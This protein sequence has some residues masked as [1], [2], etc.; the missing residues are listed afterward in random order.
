M[1][2]KSFFKNQTGL[3]VDSK[4]AV[5]GDLSSSLADVESSFHVQERAKEQSYL[6]PDIDYSNLSRHVRY[7]LASDYYSNSFKRI[8][9]QYPYDGSA[10]EKLEFYNNLTPFEKYV[11]DDLYPKYNGHVTLGLGPY[12]GVSAPDTF[13]T[14]TNPQYIRFYGGPHEGN[15]VDSDLKQENNLHVNLADGLTVEFWFKKDGWADEDD[16]ETYKEALV[17]IRNES[18]TQR[19]YLYVDHANQTQIFS[20]MQYWDEGA[21]QSMVS[22]EFETG[23]TNIADNVWRH[24]AFTFK[25]E[26]NSDVRS[27]CYINGH[28]AFALSSTPDGSNYTITGSVVGTIN[29]IGGAAPD[30]AVATTGI[31]NP[32]YGKAMSASYDEFRIWK[33]SRTG[34]QIGLNWFRNVHGGT[35]SDSTKYFYD[36]SERY[37]E[38]DLAVYFK[39]NE[40]ISSVSG[41][42]TFDAGNEVTSSAAIGDNLILDYSG[43][44][45]NGVFIGYD[46]SLSMRSEDSAIVLAIPNMSEEKDPLLFDQNPDYNNALVPLLNSGSHHDVTNGAALYNNIP[47]WMR[48]QDGTNGEQIKNLFQIVGSYF[49]TVHAQIEHVKNFKEAQ[50]VSSSNKTTDY[51][52]RLLQSSG[53][54]VPEMFVD[55]EII[56]SI[57][58]QDK[59]RVFETK[60]YN[61]KNKVYKNIYANLVTILKSKGTEKSFR[62]LFRCYGTDDELFKINLYADGVEYQIDDKTYDSVVRKRLVDF[63]GFESSDDRGGVLYQYTTSSQG[64]YGFYPTSSIVDIP[65][66][67]EAQILFPKKP[68]IPSLASLPLLTTSSLFGVHSSSYSHTDPSVPPSGDCDFQVQTRRNS[69]GFAQFVLTS[70]TG[71]FPVLTSSFFADEDKLIYDNVPW[72]LA[73][74]LYPK[75]YPFSNFVA[76]SEKFLLNFYGVKTHL[77]VTLAEFAVSES[78]SRNVAAQF[79]TGSN[80]RFFIG[81][82]RTNITGGLINRSDVKFSR[83]LV[84]N[85]FLEDEEIRKHSRNPKNF[86]FLNPYERAFSYESDVLAS[87]SF[88]LKADTL[89]LNWEFDTI[90]SIT[91]SAI[92]DSSSGSL[93]LV[94]KYPLHGFGGYNSREFPAS[95]SGFATSGDFTKLDFMQANVIQRPDSL[96]GKNMVRTLANDFDPYLINKKP[97][98]YFFAFEASKNEVI[99]RDMLNFFAD[100]VSFNNLYGE[101]VHAYRDRYKQLEHFKEFYFSKVA[102]VEDLDKFVNLYKFLDN[103]LD[104]VIMSLVPASAA[105]SDK[106][107]TVVEDHVL[108]RHKVKRP[109]E[110]LIQDFPDDIGNTDTIAGNESDNVPETS[111]LNTDNVDTDQ[112]TVPSYN[113][114]EVATGD[115]HDSHEY[116]VASDFPSAPIKRMTTVT[117][118]DR[119]VGANFVDQDGRHQA[120]NAKLRTRE[121]TQ[122]RDSDGESVQRYAA[123]ALRVEKDRGSSW[124]LVDGVGASSVF[125]KNANSVRT[126]MDLNIKHENARNLST[127]Y[128]VHAED[129]VFPQQ[130]AEEENILPDT[131][132]GS[133]TSTDGISFSID[134]MPSQL[135]DD[136]GEIGIYGRKFYSTVATV[137]DEASRVYNTYNGETVLNTLGIKILSGSHTPYESNIGFQVHYEKQQD[138]ASTAIQTL[139]SQL[140]RNPASRDIRN[141]RKEPFA[142]NILVDA[143]TNS[144]DIVINNPQIT[145]DNVDTFY[146]HSF[147]P[148]NL[149]K[150]VKRSYITELTSSFNWG[151]T[152]GEIFGISPSDRDISTLKASGSIFDYSSDAQLGA[153]TADAIITEPGAERGQGKNDV[154]DRGAIDRVENIDNDAEIRV[155]DNSIFRDRLDLENQQASPQQ[156]LNYRNLNIK[157]ALQ[158]AWS[159]P[160]ANDNK[161]YRSIGLGSGHAIYSGFSNPHLEI[162]PLQ[163]QSYKVDYDNAYITR[164]PQNNYFQRWFRKINVVRLSDYNGAPYTNPNFSTLVETDLINYA[165][166]TGTYYKEDDSATIPHS[167]E[168]FTTTPFGVQNVDF[169]GTNIVVNRTINIENREIDGT[170]NNYVN[171]NVEFLD[172]GDEFKRLH[173]Y[174]LST[175]GPHE[176]SLNAVRTRFAYPIINSAEYKN[177]LSFQTSERPD[178][179]GIIRIKTTPISCKA[180][181]NTAV[182]VFDADLHAVNYEVTYPFITEYFDSGSA[183]FKNVP[184]E[185]Q[186]DPLEIPANKNY[187]C[188]FDEVSQARNNFSLKYFDFEEYIFPRRQKAVQ[189]L[190]RYDSDVQ[191]PQGV[192]QREVHLEESS[193]GQSFPAGSYFLNC[194]FSSWPVETRPIEVAAG[195]TITA[196]DGELMQINHEEAYISFAGLGNGP[197]LNNGY[198]NLTLGYRITADNR[199]DSV[200]PHLPRR[201]FKPYIEFV[202]PELSDNLSKGAIAEYRREDHINN[203]L[204]GEKIQSSFSLFGHDVTGKALLG[205]ASYTDEIF[206]LR[207][208]HKHI[209]KF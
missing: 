113:S 112:I 35:N 33:T 116:R 86:G 90:R 157:R 45:S 170:T 23:I 196:H 46:S 104:S 78:I 180:G 202:G 147:I 70:S 102:T 144:P 76:E 120:Q 61:L 58:D 138:I 189:N 88:I 114:K 74:R 181:S 41:S 51:V 136:S 20:V 38:V 199:P 171:P 156:N 122:L 111:D 48:D 191:Y 124:P 100:V 92:L 188:I 79:L 176:H 12:G 22:T 169:A 153:G 99:S 201:P 195:S 132:R 161:S 47:Q 16:D 149:V 207:D 178:E 67:V 174:L 204:Q 82:D 193:L 139:D 81:A 117:P 151:G 184:R 57:F 137:R 185:Y 54:N 8:R 142:V 43:R 115:S 186:K 65:M 110:L 63:S 121:I 36:A 183:T 190:V 56:S 75:E 68:D 64:A 28:Q 15:I 9:T 96:Y 19:F 131:N 145:S 205:E 6:I 18:D 125:K 179:G 128:F 159:A 1:G 17:N 158:E 71:F 167:E 198:Y 168:S 206:E 119:E 25:K 129:I 154:Y 107:R 2:T 200:S 134:S 40:G 26:S 21:W 39:F 3:P 150:K 34:K 162:D 208:I 140:L 89:A 160:L 83:F 192:S 94:D 24:Y 59:K 106:I 155:F 42:G 73:V 103:A 85:S 105:T 98:K 27:T 69:A 11:Y 165:P 166:L 187:I 118:K 194:L 95:A 5:K 80:K 32:G 148:P 87:S 133:S 30:A 177:S 93:D 14:T 146:Y 29:G 55:P 66:T 164:V 143:T 72:N 7:A 91:S 127:P 141:D 37:N 13:G 10:A 108:D 175:N 209:D 52:A 203:Y 152:S 172:S 53:F 126:Q 97:V 101:A 62:N 173:A 182:L 49:D 109:Y 44:T 135:I 31:T 123:A 77:G 197:Y 130:I 163:A 50:Y 84:W 4:G 60:L